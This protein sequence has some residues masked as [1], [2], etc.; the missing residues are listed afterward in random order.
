MRQEQ[1]TIVVGDT[2]TAARAALPDG[3]RDD[4]E[5]DFGVP[6]VIWKQLHLRLA[7]K[8][9]SVEAKSIAKCS[10]VGICGNIGLP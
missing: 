2:S 6:P 4:L 5:R 7:E 3:P 10:P 8:S 1:S 9:Y